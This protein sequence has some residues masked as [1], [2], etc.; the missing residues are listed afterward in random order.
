MQVRLPPDF[1]LLP[2]AV[3][4]QATFLDLSLQL[5]PR[6][7]LTKGFSETNPDTRLPVEVDYSR[8][9]ENTNKKV[10]K[11]G[12]VRKRATGV[13]CKAITTA[14][15]ETSFP[16]RKFW[17]MTSIVQVLVLEMVPAHVLIPKF[18]NMLPYMVD[19]TYVEDLGMERLS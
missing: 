15:D 13:H 8:G 16:G 4:A 6:L 5:S 19:F 7:A 1:P 17:K 18:G 12:R 2:S 9:L 3:M 10:E 14:D 11:S